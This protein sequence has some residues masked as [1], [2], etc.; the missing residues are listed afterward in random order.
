MTLRAPFRSAGGE[1]AERNVLFVRVLTDVGE[2][3]GECAA[4]PGPTY[5]EEWLG[6]ASAVIEDHLAP[7]LV[8]ARRVPPEGVASA[9]GDVVGHHMAKAA[10]EAAVLDAALRAEG[11]SLGSW[12]G[13][14]G[15]AV[16]VGA[17]VGLHDRVD[18]VAAEAAARVEEGYRH[19]KLKIVPG[20]GPGIVSAVR[21]LVGDDALLRVDA[22]GTYGPESYDELY[23][24]DELGLLM[25]EQPFA[26]DR[27]LAHGE[28]AADLRTRICLDESIRS[29]NDLDTALALGAASVAN[30]KPAR[31]GGLFEALRLHDRCEDA[32]VEAWVGGMLE[33]GVGRTLAVALAALPG[34]TVPGDT[35]A[36]DRYWDRDLTE[37]FVL[38]DGHLL[39]RDEPGIAAPDRTRL[40]LTGAT[41]A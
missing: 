18:D 21:D 25:I 11:R 14:A 32:G 16:E 29:V 7:R 13:V 27:W 17:A 15:E 24:L 30:V 31:V 38:E 35:S 3:W 40:S 4:L 10:L 36:S 33:T 41:P 12:M 19:L 22:N 39:V 5:T 1:V 26:A 20:R 37:P 23:E 9:L 2:G 8:A 34:F 28:M 6:G